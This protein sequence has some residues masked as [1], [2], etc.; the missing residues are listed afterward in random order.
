M[1]RDDALEPPPGSTAFRPWTLDDFN[2]S[3]WLSG[4]TGVGFGYPTWVGLDVS[5][6]RNVNET[7]YV[8]VPFVV[9]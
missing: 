4:V 7:V 1:P 8:R 3:T 6:M 2:D 9:R 5:A